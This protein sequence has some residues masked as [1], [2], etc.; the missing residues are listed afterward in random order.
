MA[1]PYDS[2]Y[3]RF[4]QKIRDY[5]LNA[6]LSSN[7]DLFNSQL[8]G[9]LNSAT[10]RFTYCVQD[11]SQRDDNMKLFFIDLSP[12]EQEILSLCMWV[13]YLRPFENSSNL[14]N[15]SFSSADLQFYSPANQLMQLKDL[16]ARAKS[17]TDELIHEYYI[18]SAY[19]DLNGL[20]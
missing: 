10:S 11:L 12:L 18:R 20:S 7:P 16:C 14:L 1:T 5:D 13:E 4:L 8:L 17:E 19:G 6:E 2:I 3:S 15:Q 9:W